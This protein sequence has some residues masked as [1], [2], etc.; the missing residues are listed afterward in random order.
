MA[1]FAHINKEG[2]VDNVIV[3]EA[4]V[5]ATGAWGDPSEWVQTSFNTVQGEYKLGVNA[6]EIG[7]VKDKSARNRKNFAGIGFTYDPISDAFI[8]PQPFPSWT[9]NKNTC[10]WEAP[11]LIPDVKE[12]MLPLWDESLKDWRI[13]DRITLK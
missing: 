4:D 10:R 9:L 1:H 8:P 11:V 7:T 3:I 6:K 13:V 12:G 5:L 2:I